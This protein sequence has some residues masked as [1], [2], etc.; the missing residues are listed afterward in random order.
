MSRVQIRRARPDDAPLIA[1]V[2]AA[3]FL[4]TFAEVIVGA[5][6]VAH[7]ANRNSARSYQ[8]AL[9]EA[10]YAL[11]VAETSTGAPVGFAML[12]PPD[13]P[14]AVTPQDI[15]L[16]RIYLL[17]AFHGEGAGR[18]LMDAAVAEAV[19]RGKSRLLLGVAIDNFRALAFYRAA[20]FVQIG[21]RQFPVGDA[22][23]DD[24]VLARTL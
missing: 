20:G 12:T 2:A 19:A 24:V 18:A 8:A 14:V 4:E 3:T 7:C 15:E 23:Y 11:W 6:I 9:A 22:V 1:L 16:K 21:T 5:D 17:S 10:E 13:L